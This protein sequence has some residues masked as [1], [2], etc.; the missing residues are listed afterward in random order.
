M[1]TIFNNKLVRYNLLKLRMVVYV[2]DI[3]QKYCLTI[4]QAKCNTSQNN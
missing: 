2:A 3:V 1:I 4:Y